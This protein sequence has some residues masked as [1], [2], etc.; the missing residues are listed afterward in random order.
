MKQFF[1]AVCVMACNFCAR[2]EK[3]NRH[4]YFGDPLR[5]H[6][7]A[8]MKNFQDLYPGMTSDLCIT[9]LMF[10]FDSVLRTIGTPNGNGVT[11][12]RNGKTIKIGYPDVAMM[13][14]IHKQS[15]ITESNCG[16]RASLGWGNTGTDFFFKN[17]RVSVDGVKEKFLSAD[18]GM[19]Y[20]ISELSGI[21]IQ[22]Q[23]DMCGNPVFLVNDLSRVQEGGYNPPHEPEDR[24]P[25]PQEK[26]PGNVTVINNITQEAPLEAQQYAQPS[27]NG[28]G[29]QNYGGGNYAQPTCGFGVS[30]SIGIGG[31]YPPT[32]G[33]YNAQGGMYNYGYAQPLCAPVVNNYYPPQDCGHWNS[34]HWVEPVRSQPVQVRNHNAYANNGYNTGGHSVAP[35][36]TNDH[37]GHNVAP[38]GNDYGNHNGAPG[39]NSGN[40]NYDNG[41]H[42]TAPRYANSGNG[43]T[44]SRRQQRIAERNAV[45]NNANGDYVYSNVNSGRG[46]NMNVNQSQQSQHRSNPQNG[47]GGGRSFFGNGNSY[48]QR[49]PAPQN[50]GGGR[51][52][53]NGGGGQR[54]MVQ[55]QPQNRGGGGGGQRQAAPAQ[56]RGGGRR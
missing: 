30:A 33:G 43:N 54:Q 39:T 15:T 50:N 41:N 12:S 45:Q 5:H 38:G 17:Q 51:S 19:V 48:A 3:M 53:F 56:Q 14:N 24:T 4:P 37:G 47:N 46:N 29:A 25:A 27:Y 6:T 16:Q 1:L 26:Q 36:G 44:M 21:I 11:I 35:N 2:A 42:G 9:H 23:S 7:E 49:Q 52:F 18:L 22:Y 20:S 10:A 40:N 28:S 8:E 34:N 55:A 32:C 31:Y 13:Q